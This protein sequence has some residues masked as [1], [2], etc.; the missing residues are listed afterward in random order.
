MVMFSAVIRDVVL[1]EEGGQQ[2]AL[3]EGRRAQ[4][5]LEQSPSP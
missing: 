4:Q 1:G 3:R 2:Q 5:A